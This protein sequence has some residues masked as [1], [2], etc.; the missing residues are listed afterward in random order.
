VDGN[1]KA[2]ADRGWN[3]DH[4]ELTKERNKKVIQDAYQLAA[5]HGK[6]N[7]PLDDLNFDSGI[8]KSVMDNIVEGRIRDRALQQ[9]CIDQEEGIQSRRLNTFN[10][11]LKLTAGIAFNAGILEIS[12]G[13]VHKRVLEQTK[14]REQ[15][16]EDAKDRRRKQHENAMNKVKGIREKTE[17][18]TKWNSQELHTMVSWFK[19]PGD[20]NIPK[21]KEQLLRRYYL[22]C[23]HSESEP[24]HKK[25]DEPPVL[26]DAE[27][28]LVPALET[29]PDA[30]ATCDDTEAVEQERNFITAVAPADEDDAAEAL[31]HFMN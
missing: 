13:R 9:A 8:S 7:V 30:V 3:L 15:A 21:R 18:P 22:T 10:N 26:D 31:L 20:S 11:C 27:P 4:P 28:L 17:D 6:E 12:D 16:E 19:R 24:K 23:H 2:I 1:K 5:L 25:E 14:R 29:I